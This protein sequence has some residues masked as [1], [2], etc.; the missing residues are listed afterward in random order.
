MART[1]SPERQKLKQDAIRIRMELAWSER[2]IAAH[3]GID[4]AT[5]HRFVK[6]LTLDKVKHARQL[7]HNSDIETLHNLP[8]IFNQV[9]IMDCLNGMAKLPHE[10]TD[11]VL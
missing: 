7:L 9:Y 11:S 2:E 6:H 8:L 3:L 1:L 5:S 4:P 10:C